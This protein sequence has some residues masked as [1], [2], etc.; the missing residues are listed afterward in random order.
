MDCVGLT[1]LYRCLKS[2]VPDGANAFQ[3]VPNM[4][5]DCCLNL[6]V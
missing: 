4:R 2:M 3:I 6:M 1:Q 5:L